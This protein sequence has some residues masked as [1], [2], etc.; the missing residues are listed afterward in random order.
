MGATTIEPGAESTVA[1]SMMMHKGMEG[2]HLFRV[3]V[4][5]QNAAGEKGKLQLLVRAN[6][7]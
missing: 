1:V 5:V 7:Q 3:T 2:P 4:P 6:F